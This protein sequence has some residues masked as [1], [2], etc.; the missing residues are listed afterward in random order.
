TRQTRRGHEG[1]GQSQTRRRNDHPHRPTRKG[2]L[3]VTRTLAVLLALILVSP[4]RA[5]SPSDPIKVPFELLPSGHFLVDVTLNGKG[6]YKLIFDTGAPLTLLNNR[7]AKD[8]G[9]NKKKAGL[10]LVG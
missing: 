6:P 1:A 3:T 4:A 2:Y 5:Q 9:V 10:S 8:G 7:I